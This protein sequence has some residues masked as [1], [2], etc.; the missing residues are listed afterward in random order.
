M[1]FPLWAKAQFPVQVTTQII[2]PYSVTLS[3]YTT[4]TS[5]R[6]VVNLLLGDV[7]ELDRQVLLK[8]FIEGNGLLI[9]STDMVAGATPV[10]LDGGIPIRLTNIDLNPYFQLENLSGITPSQYG[11]PLPSGLYRFCFEVYDDL[12][13]QLISKRSC[14][15]AY[16][17]LNDP[18]LLNLPARDENVSFS[19][20]QNIVF[21]WTPRHINATNIKYEFTLTEIWDTDIDPQA[22]F[23][24]SPP[25]YQTT[26]TATTLLYGPAETSLL[27][28]KRYGWRVR[29][30]ATDGINELSLFKNN[31]YS[32]I[33]HFYYTEQCNPPQFI[34]AE[35]NSHNR[36][37]VYWEGAAHQQYKVHYR[38]KHGNNSGWFEVDAYNE[39]ATIFKLEENT[40]YQY[41]VGGQC[42]VNGAYTYSRI[43]EFTTAARGQNSE[44]S[45]GVTPEVDITNQ[46]PLPQI[47][48]NAQFTAGEFP[49]TVKQVTGGNGSFSGWGYIVVPYLAH[50]RIRVEFTGIKINTDHQLTDG[51]L[52]TSYDPKWSS[53][54]DTGDTLAAVTTLLETISDEMDSLVA[55]IKAQIDF[56]EQTR[57]AIK[58]MQAWIDDEHNGLSTDQREAYQSYIN[59]PD[60]VKQDIKQLREDIATGKKDE[61]IRKALATNLVDTQ[62]T[63]E[64]EAIQEV[65][66]TPSEQFTADPTASGNRVYLSPA[67]V[68]VTLPKT[69][70]PKFL[71]P[72]SLQVPEGVL[73]GFTLGDNIYKGYYH[74]GTFRGYKTKKGGT[75]YEFLP[76]P[77]K[78]NIRAVIALSVPYLECE[79]IFVEGTYT[80]KTINPTGEGP[81]LTGTNLSFSKTNTV[82]ELSNK[83][84]TFYPM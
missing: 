56:H 18:P 26:T 57:L 6:L 84:T 1:L 5:E 49:V 7:A 69:A 22:A 43:F 25:L 55:L 60:Q 23:L 39:N 81:L 61:E 45:C 2:P 3:D 46:E 67:G 62:Y 10:F 73:S 31:G 64:D 40:T 80:A 20:P 76:L 77:D 33:Y 4:A 29:A 72:N 53:V 38:K 19:D 47:G 13:G 34:L 21:N 82:L 54:E 8:L 9:W 70:K 41:R 16:L 37:S 66:F 74:Q 48:V 28:G 42:D 36:A 17:V 50:T 83:Y 71:K 30:I 68:P 79:R 15:T 58:M 59:N 32:E 63:P 75:P 12:T 24:S 65:S 44:F 51:V 14:A 52:I 35:S 78:D 27:P 11:N